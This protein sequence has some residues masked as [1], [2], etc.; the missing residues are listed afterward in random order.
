MPD[1]KVAV[2]T[3]ALT[4]IG[5]LLALACPAR[6]ALAQ[7][8]LKT[9]LVLYDG[10]REFSSI[11]LTDRGIEATLRDALGDRVTIFREYMDLTRIS[12]P[13]YADLL[14]AFY[15]S[16]YASNTPDVIIA[17]RGR[18]LEFLLMEGDEL[19]PGT[20]IVSA[21]MA[22]QQLRT[23]ALPAAVTGTTFNVEYWPTLMLARTL[24]PEI[25]H[26]VIVTGASPNDR[27]LEALV[28]D[29]LERHS[30]TLTFTYL[31]GLSVDDTVQR[32]S[33]LPARTALL[34][35]SFAQ[36][37]QGRSFLPTDAVRLIARAANVPT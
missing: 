22:T 3:T 16:K 12:A 14:R 11:Q 30:G 1:A 29:E 26:V 37:S 23:R 35:V 21:G 13:N 8:N 33:H 32:V 9:V 15:R 17:V 27:A 18:P 36:D 25:D 34:F 20:P 28:R 5:V 19:F 6:D 7:G 10:G 2:R 4:L 24:Q 31:S